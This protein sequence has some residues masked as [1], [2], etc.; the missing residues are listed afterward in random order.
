MADFLLRKRVMT[1]VMIGQKGLPARSGGIERHVDALAR[2]LARLGERVVVYG[3]RWYVGSDAAPNGVEQRFSPGFHTKHL[4]AITH[5]FTALLD[6]RRVHPDVVHL[7]GTGIALLA[8]MARLLH[9]RAKVVV[10]FHCIDR[11]LAKWGRVARL[12]FRLGEWLACYC[13]HTTIA[14]SQEL[15]KYCQQTYGRQTVYITHPFTIDIAN[16]N[17]EFLHAHGLR[18]QSY[19][20]FV[21]RL[22]PDKQA[23]RLVD[24]YAHASVLF[25]EL[26]AHVPLVIIGG[27]SA[28]D[29]YAKRLKQM[30]QRT[31]NVRL[32]GERSGEE[33]RALQ[34]YALAHVFP[35]SSEGLAIS[36][37]EAGAYARPSIVTDLPQIREATGGYAIEVR[38]QDTEDLCRGLIQ[39][40]SQPEKARERLGQAMRSHVVKTFSPDE[41]IKDVQRL[42][43]EILSDGAVESAPSELLR[44]SL[45]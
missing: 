33:L 12:A 45:K 32:L 5:S 18:E 3:R 30:A 8:P 23:H 2:G 20:A 6:A 29:A 43:R 24:A 11:T 37:L 25:P 13:A 4:D 1:I 22:I 14:V 41:R 9:P 10:T 39:M 7:H 27:S 26:F 16:P 38:V 40:V 34:A 31:P 19:L 35:T 21:A 36:M 17:P 44:Y 15:V 42:Y 28:T